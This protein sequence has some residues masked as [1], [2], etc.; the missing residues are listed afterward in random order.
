VLNPEFNLIGN[1][2]TE[3][4]LIMITFLEF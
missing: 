3:Y 2:T 4:I 1:S